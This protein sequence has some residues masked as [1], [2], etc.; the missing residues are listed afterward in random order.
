MI[1]RDFGISFSTLTGGQY[2]LLLEPIAYFKFQGQN[3]AMT[4][5][6]AALYDQQLSGGLRSRM[7]S[8]AHQNL[9][10]AMF[11]ELPDLGL[12]AYSGATTG[13][14]SNDTI[15]TY[16]GMGTVTYTDYEEPPE[17]GEYTVEY[18]VNMEVITAVTLYTIDEINYNDYA[19][20][21]F[22]MMGEPHQM[23][24]PVLPLI[25]ASIWN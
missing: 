5:H 11:L 15:L 12:P 9:P 24:L 3:V 23:T 21:T 10:L 16:L 1:A 7:V 13:R 22:R 8:L 6:E 20:V 25:Q 19:T 14:Q 4:A 18:R 17:P 2:K